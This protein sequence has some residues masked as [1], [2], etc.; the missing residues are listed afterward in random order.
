ML[1]FTV[2]LTAIAAADDWP[3]KTSDRRS[4]PAEG[5]LEGEADPPR[6][7]A[8]V[9]VSAWSDTELVGALEERLS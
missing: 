3:P 1:W 7:D 5:A 9:A 6:R 4:L 8:K 2:E